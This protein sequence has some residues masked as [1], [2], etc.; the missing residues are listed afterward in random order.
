MPSRQMTSLLAV[1]MTAA[2][3]CVRLNLAGFAAVALPNSLSSAA[4]AYPCEKTCRSLD[5]KANVA[6][7]GL[8]CFSSCSC[9]GNLSIWRTVGSCNA[10]STPV[11]KV[12]EAA[13]VY[14]RMG[15]DLLQAR[16]VQGPE[17]FGLEVVHQGA[18]NYFAQIPVLRVKGAYILRVELRSQN[19]DH[20][21]E[22]SVHGGVGFNIFPAI[23]VAKSVPLVC[24][25]STSYDW[26]H[27]LPL[28]TSGTST[29]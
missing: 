12:A 20:I 16:I 10:T 3:L 25:T 9:S 28:C 4:S 15:P 2:C 14:L 1:A 5:S 26:A 8:V 6:F 24:G 29:G 22:Y 27:L 7:E 18:C 21:R 17:M 19:Y 11:S 13:A 23:V